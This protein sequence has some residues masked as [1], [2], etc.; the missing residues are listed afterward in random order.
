MRS[1]IEKVLCIPDA[2]SRM[3]EDESEDTITIAIGAI[4]LVTKNIVDVANTQDEWYQKRYREVVSNPEKFTQR[5]VI[6]GQLYF[7]RP[8]PMVS[9]IVK[10]L[11]R[12][13]LV[14][15]KE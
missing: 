1:F 15:P 2:L 12:W 13:K 8:K 6:D 9:E 7:L 10:N 3:F 14:L 5:K 11:D 4:N